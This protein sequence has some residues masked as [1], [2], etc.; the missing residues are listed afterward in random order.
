MWTCNIF[1]SSLAPLAHISVADPGGGGRNRRPQN[2]STVI[3]FYNTFCS[4]ML[5]NGAQVALESIK[6]PRASRALKRALAGSLPKGTSDFA[7]VMCVRLHNLLR[8]LNE[9]PRS[10]PAYIYI[11]FLNVCYCFVGILSVILECH[12]ISNERKLHW[13][14]LKIFGPLKIYIFL[15][16][17]PKYLSKYQ[18]NIEG[19][20]SFRIS[21]CRIFLSLLAYSH[22]F[23]IVSVLSV[24]LLFIVPYHIDC[25]DSPKNNYNRTFS[26]NYF[27]N[28]ELIWLCFGVIKV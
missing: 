1:L 26:I 16:Q 15:R 23:L 13:L 25:T 19:N 6:T 21:K 22:I 18:Q 14:Y 4:R 8:P 5:K 3:L 24:I 11:N 2:G 7:L 9:N 27:Q 17:S 28:C 20:R 10:A 12:I